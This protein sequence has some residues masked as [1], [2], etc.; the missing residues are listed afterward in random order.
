MNE[1]ERT[2][3]EALR[4]ALKLRESDIQSQLGI[5]YVYLVA[6]IYRGLALIYRQQGR[7]EEALRAFGR[8]AAA[9][10]ASTAAVRPEMRAFMLAGGYLELGGAQCAMQQWDNAKATLSKA[11][12]IAE[13]NPGGGAQ[14]KAVEAQLQRVARQTPC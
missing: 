4:V 9:L 10:E 1:A 5:D 6:D 13:K 2:W 11:R 7:N 8:A 3:I 14:L 12:T